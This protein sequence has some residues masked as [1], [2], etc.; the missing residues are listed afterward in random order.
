MAKRNALGAAKHFMAEV[1][2]EIGIRS[3]SI[4]TPLGGV[5]GYILDCEEGIA[6]LI[7]SRSRC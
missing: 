2:G 5:F 7:F 3:F 1:Q 4:D 6:V